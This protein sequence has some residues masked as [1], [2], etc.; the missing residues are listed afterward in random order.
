MYTYVYVHTYCTCVHSYSLHRKCGLKLTFCSQYFASCA[1]IIKL[2]QNWQ[3]T[4]VLFLS[5]SICSAKL[6]SSVI[7]WFSFC[8]YFCFHPKM[9]AL[10][11]L[12]PATITAMINT[13]TTAGINRCH[14]Q[15]RSENNRNIAEKLPIVGDFELNGN[16]LAAIFKISIDGTTICNV[17]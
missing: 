16:M 14:S 3:R 12:F 8:N 13:S 11:L 17:G 7:F 10:L 4:F 1:L 6:A 9:R 5:F 2:L 15:W